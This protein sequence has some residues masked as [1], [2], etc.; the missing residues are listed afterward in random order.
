MIDQVNL[1]EN[2][3]NT[4]TINQLYKILVISCDLENINFLKIIFT[5]DYSII[6][7]ESGA[8]GIELAKQLG[9]DL[10]LLDL[11]LRD[12]CA[13]HVC[14]SLR[15]DNSTSHIPI[16]TITTNFDTDGRIKSLKNG[17]DDVIDKQFN[18]T[19]ISLRVQNKIERLHEKKNFNKCFKCGNL[20]INDSKHEVSIKNEKIELGIIEFKLLKYLVINFEHIMS[21]KQILDDVWNGYIVSS[22][23]IDTHILSL[24]KKLTSFNREIV[25]VYGKGYGI[26]MKRSIAADCYS[27][28]I[29][30]S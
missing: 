11:N 6:A 7:S 23:T 18:A 22:R 28:I 26:K 4:L 3:V 19:E 30:V 5:N 17:A 1:F 14:N 27:N 2:K 13:F 9:P 20:L 12:L 25:S 29:K 8:H 15:I 24:R 21:R 10:I 16:I